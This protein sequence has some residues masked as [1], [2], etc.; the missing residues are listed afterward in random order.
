MLCCGHTQILNLKVGTLVLTLPILQIFTYNLEVL[1]S[2]FWQKFHISLHFL[3]HLYQS[4][5]NRKATP[6]LQNHLQGPK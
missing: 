5:K 6:V 1:F 3:F 2:S 4:G